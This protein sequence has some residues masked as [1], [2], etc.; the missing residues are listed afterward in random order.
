MGTRTSSR[1]LRIGLVAA[2]F[3]VVLGGSLVV[4]WMVSNRIN[5]GRWELPDTDDLV[6]VLH[7]N[8]RPS[9]VIFLDGRALTVEPGDDAAARLRSS[10]VASTGPRA[11]KVRG[12]NGGASRWRRVRACVQALYAPFDVVV[13]DDVPTTDDYVRVMVGGRPGDIGVDNRRVSGLAPFNGEVIPRAVVFAFANQVG[14]DPQAVCE[15]IGMEVAHVYGLDH[16]YDCHDVMTYRKACGPKRFVD[17]EVP[18]GETKPRPCEG[19]APTQ[20]SYR[21]LLEVLGPHR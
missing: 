10:I 12:W 15:T 11:R 20:S 7:R 6:R 4:A 13:T 18:C 9:R 14:N 17:R 2:L 19:G 21:R 3:V 1:W 8:G 16:E 5:T